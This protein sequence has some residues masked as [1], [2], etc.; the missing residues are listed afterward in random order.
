M[1]FIN[2]YLQNLQTSYL[3]EKIQRE[4]ERFGNR[5][6]INLGIG[7]ISLPLAPAIAAS[8]AKAAEEM[9]H[10]ESL[11]GYGPANGYSF[12]RKAICENEY[13]E[14]G[15]DPDEIFI[16]FGA[17]GDLVQLQSLFSS[18]TIVALQNPT[19][20]VYYES[21]FIAGK[22]RFVYLPCTAENNWKAKPPKQHCD[23]IYLCSPNNPT[24]SCFT[25]E[26]L[27]Q[28]V[29]Y[30]EKEGAIILYDA[31]YKAFI[32]SDDLPKSIF[33]IEGAKKVAVEISSFSKTAGFTNLRCSYVTISKQNPLYTL[34]K[35]QLDTT[36]GGVSYPIQKGAEAV[37]SK[38]G[39]I[40]VK[41]TLAVYQ[42]NADL[43]KQSLIDQQIK[44]HSGENSPYLWCKIPTDLSSWDFFRLLL[45]KL[46]MIVIPGSGFGSCGEG[47]FRISSFA[48]KATTQRAIESLATLHSLA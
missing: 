1:S 7:D 15:F 48:D 13:R 16:G 12:L 39:Q 37:Y 20:P 34:W 47:Y 8:I 35:R 2:P 9:T 46:N 42:S 26:E 19:Y 22:K 30:A 41:E 45:D 14:L 10:Q 23:L 6:W 33:E 32:Q 29:S 21:N 11:K 4:K 43:L 3:F 31:A 40:Q 5:P 36:F 38:E 17:K 18:N 28:W 44:I 24:G 25:K 27:E